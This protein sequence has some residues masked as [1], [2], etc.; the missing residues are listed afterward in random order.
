VGAFSLALA[1]LAWLRPGFLCVAYRAKSWPR[2]P[3]GPCG[4]RLAARSSH[5]IVT[6]HV[7]LFFV[8][9]SIT[10]VTVV[11]LMPFCLA[12]PCQTASTRQLELGCSDSCA[13]CQAFHRLIARV[14][15]LA[16][17]SPSGATRLNLSVIAHLLVPRQRREQS[18]RFSSPLIDRSA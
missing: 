2:L 6:R 4:T 3:R 13:S 7:P 17:S 16:L 5:H 15:M 12:C 9:K 14:H 8:S 10:S 18:H 11:R 1:G